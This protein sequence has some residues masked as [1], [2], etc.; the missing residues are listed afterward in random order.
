M[1]L[2]RSIR[3]ILKIKIIQ[4][5]IYII[6]TFT[7]DE[8]DI[9]MSFNISFPNNEVLNGNLP[10]TTKSYISEKGSIPSHYLAIPYN[11]KNINAS[12]LAV[13]FFISP[14]AQLQK[15]KAKIWGDPNILTLDKLDIKWQK[16]F[17]KLSD[18]PARVKA[19]DLQKKLPEPHPSWMEEIERI[20]IKNYG[21]IN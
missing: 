10:K 4:K 3:L 12:K 11:S 14:E 8:V 17:K 20:W 5:I 13:N 7:D 1:G 19:N 6:T 16:K 21:S 2:A 18:G 9:G 15:Q